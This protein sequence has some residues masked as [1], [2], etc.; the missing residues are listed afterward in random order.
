MF[1][2]G[3]TPTPGQRSLLSEL[4]AAV[5]Q[6]KV[7]MGLLDSGEFYYQEIMPKYFVHLAQN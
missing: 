4:S 6:R 1:N 7:K 3:D 2:T 5:G